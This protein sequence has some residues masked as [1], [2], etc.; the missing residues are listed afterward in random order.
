MSPKKAMAVFP[1]ISSFR[2]VMYTIDLPP[3]IVKP[4]PFR[5]GW[6]TFAALVLSN[7]VPLR[8]G[9]EWLGS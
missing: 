9:S 3:G 1:D 5:C 2:S 4:I 6:F 8:E 7:G